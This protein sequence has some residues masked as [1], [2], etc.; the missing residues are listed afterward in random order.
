M[1]LKGAAALVGSSA[2]VFFAAACAQTPAPAGADVAGGRQCF[3]PTQ[4]TT[5]N[6]VDENSVQVFVGPSDVYSLDLAGACP[7]VDWALNV[8]LQS[9]GGSS[10]VCGGGDARLLV[11]G[12]MGPQ[13]C[14]VTNIQKLSPEAAQA[15]RAGRGS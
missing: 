12:P 2:A 9:T 3:Y 10:W 11:Q 5:F 13:S 4:V 15:A 6:A 1:G 7:D 8:T 14:L